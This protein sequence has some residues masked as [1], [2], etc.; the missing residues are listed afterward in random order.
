MS[1]K[2]K[3][4]PRSAAFWPV[5]GLMTLLAAA[6]IAYFAGP[7]VVDWMDDSNVVRGFP[8]AGIPEANVDWIMRGIIFVVV[9]MLVSL[10]VAAAVPKKKSTVNE[11]MLTKQ[12]QEMVNE[13]KAMKVRMKMMNKKNREL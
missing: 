9:F 8:P 5:I 2:A 7:A 3:P 6:A 11:K 4:K 10:V 12:R 1:M 13:K